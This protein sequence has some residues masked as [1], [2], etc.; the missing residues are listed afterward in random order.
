MTNPNYDYDQRVIYAALKR[1]TTEHGLIQAAFQFWQK[2]FA[3]APLDV[4]DYCNKLVA[5]LGLNDGQKK[6]LMVAMHAASSRLPEDLPQV[7]DG[8]MSAPAAVLGS[9]ESKKEQKPKAIQKPHLVVCAAFLQ[10]LVQQLRKYHRDD[11]AELATILQNEG[12]DDN[13]PVVHSAIGQWLNTGLGSLVLNDNV[14]Q[15]HCESIAHHIYLLVCELIGPVESDNLVH[16][17]I[18]EVSKLDAAREYDPI[19]LT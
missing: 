19:N 9:Q 12:V 16:R 15:A 6:S 18:S 8:L 14:T 1:M 2:D 5:Y 3:N 10:Q 7:P 13:D 17:V 4:I 11:A